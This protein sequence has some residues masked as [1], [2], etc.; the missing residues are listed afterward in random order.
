MGAPLYLKEL[1]YYLFGAAIVL[2]IISIDYRVLLRVNYPIYA[3]D[4][5]PAGVGAPL[6]Q[7]YGGAQRWINLGFI[8]LQPSELAKLSWSS[9]WPVIIAARIPEKDSVCWTCPRTCLL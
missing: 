3:G 4:H 5:R 9:P 2:L 6:R 1:T 8:R 7:D